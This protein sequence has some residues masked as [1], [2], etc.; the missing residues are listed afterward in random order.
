[1]TKKDTKTPQK[2]PRQPSLDP[3]DAHDLSPFVAHLEAIADWGLDIA[4]RLSRD[5][6]EDLESIE[7]VRAFVHAWLGRRRIRARWPFPDLLTTLATILFAAIEIELGIDS[8]ALMTPFRTAPATRL[9]DV[10][11]FPGARQD[12]H[13]TVVIRRLPGRR[14][15][16]SGFTHL[17]A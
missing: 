16:S 8:V 3:I 14:N 2:A 17:A 15:A 4:A 13:P 5:Y 7:K 11:R 10:L 12:S 9:D 1:M 6:D